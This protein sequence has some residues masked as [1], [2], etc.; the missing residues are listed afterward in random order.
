MTNIRRYYQPNS[1]VFITSVVE[2]RNPIFELETNYELYWDIFNNVAKIH[3]FEMLAWV[4]LPDHFHWL[5]KLTEDN[6]DFSKILGSFKGNFTYKYKQLHQ[7]TQPLTLWQ[8]RF[9]DHVIRNEG[10]LKLHLDYIHWNPIKHNYVSDPRKWKQS[11]FE[12]WIKEGLYDEAWGV[13]EPISIAKM[14]LE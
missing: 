3:S 14:N 5:L 2:K 9:W 12:Y 11:S 7:I 13:V 8:R 4:I 1:I 6:K 10:D